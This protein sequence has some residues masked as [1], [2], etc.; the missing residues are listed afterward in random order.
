L[1]VTSEALASDPDKAQHIQG[2]ADHEA[3]IQFPPPPR[4]LRRRREAVM[5]VLKTFAQYVSKLR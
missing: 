2:S 3:E 5:V 1:R 4:E